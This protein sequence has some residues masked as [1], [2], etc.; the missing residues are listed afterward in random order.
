MTRAGDRFRSAWQ[1][2]KAQRGLPQAACD[3]CTVRFTPQIAERDE[4]GGVVG[5]V[6]CPR[7]H[8]FDSYR[9][10]SDGVAARAALASAK[11]GTPE[12]RRLLAVIAAHT[13]RAG[14]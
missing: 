9:M 11:S 10:D 2:Q 3:V 13:T 14:Q 1:Q 5:Y 8:R 6:E 4:A 7:G 12:A